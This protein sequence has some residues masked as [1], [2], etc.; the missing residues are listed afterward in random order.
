MARAGR[1]LAVAVVAGLLAV[2]PMSASGQC[3]GDCN[4]DGAVSID[5]LLKAVNRALVGCA[6]DGVCQMGECPR[7]LAACQADLAD[8]QAHVAPPRLPASG[9]ITAF[10]PGSDGD[11]RAGAPLTYTDNGDGTVTDGNTGLIWE[12][13]DRAGGIHDVDKRV[14]WGTTAEPFSMNGTIVTDFLATLNTPPCF[15]GNCAWRIPNIR[16]LQS[17]VDY[18]IVPA[19]GPVVDAAFNTNCVADC[20]ADGSG[21]PRC[22]CSA[23]FVYWSSTTG[24]GVPMNAWVV[25]F[26]SGLVAF[27][28]KSFAGAVRAVRD[29]R[30]GS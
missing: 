23:A 12:K 7:E 27:F 22:S 5:E 4:V 9:Q 28:L 30:S 21:D 18:E 20:A 3:C 13:K 25:D 14:S 29:G 17:L 8:C 11:V 24:R 2:V 1:G 19:S 16:E 10:G 15:A 6:D 26:D